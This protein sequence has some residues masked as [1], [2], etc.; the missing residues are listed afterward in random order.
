M[1]ESDCLYSLINRFALQVTPTSGSPVNLVI[2]QDI[3]TGQPSKI[4]L[5]PLS[6]LPKLKL[7]GECVMFSA[8]TVWGGRNNPLFANLPDLI[9]VNIHGNSHLTLLARLLKI[10]SDAQCCGLRG[11]LNRLG[12]VLIIII[13]RQQIEM[14]TNVPGLLNG[15]ADRRLSKAIVSMHEAPGKLWSNENLADLAGLS[16]SRFTQLFNQQMGQ[17]AQSYLRHWRMILASQD[18]ERG[19]RIQT[20]ATRYGYGSS[21]ALGRAFQKQFGTNPIAHRK[22]P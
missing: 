17:T 11:V 16:R 10:E 13:F 3:Q 4:I 21:E 5:A 15:L 18:I 14:G 2:L 6:H 8:R 20:I 22:S 7:V 12:E 1:S 9:E 19:E